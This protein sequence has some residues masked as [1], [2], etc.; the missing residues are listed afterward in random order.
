MNDA[1][2]SSIQLAMLIMGLVFGSTAILNPSTGAGHDS[3]LSFLLAWIGGFGLMGIYVWIARLN[4]EKCLIE[5][6][7]KQF[8]KVIGNIVACT[9]IWYF[10]HLSALV[11]RN[12][13]EYVTATNYTETPIIFVMIFFLLVVVYGV[14]NGLEVFARPTELFMPIVIFF[15]LF[16]GV[17]LIGRFEWINALPFLENG[18]M[19]VLKT[20]FGVLSFPFGETV[21]FLM[22]FPA[23]NEK[24]KLL[25]T[26]FIALGI[27]G[28]VIF[29]IVVRDLLVL[30]PNMM[31]P[32]KIIFPPAV[33]TE[34]ISENLQL[35]TLISI[36]FL[37][38]GGIKISVCLYA[39]VMGITQIFN[40]DDYKPFVLP[41]AAIVTP[42]SIWLYDNIFEMIDW[43]KVYPVY[44]A[45]F[46]II[47]PILLLIVSLVRNKKENAKPQSNK[48]TDEE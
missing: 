34:L 3:W 32:G 40:L 21:V 7:Q 42:L 46:Q 15:A 5:I 4:S 39:A 23:L 20:G 14:K 41:V 19:P 28:A 18:I 22:I 47:I 6:L 44:S 17:V 12:Y 35:E 25:K 38:G 48:E 16:L 33:S 24:E 9:Y 27:I 36:N 1:R 11:L 37:I 31:K 10:M 43:I 45:P 13:G 8:G 29:S 30:G 26:T 2:I